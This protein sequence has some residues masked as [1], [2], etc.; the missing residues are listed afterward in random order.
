MIEHLLW[1]GNAC[2]GLKKTPSILI[3]PF[4]IP[5][6]SLPPDLI[7]ISHE[8]Y[9]NCS[10]ADVKKLRGPQ[11]QVIAS[12]T[13]ATE[14]DGEAKILRPW[15]TLNFGRMSIRAMP[16][17]TFTGE[18]PAQREDVGFLISADYTDLYYAGD[19]DFVPELRNLRCDIA[20]LP[21]GEG[22]SM[23]PESVLAFVESAKPRY[24]IPSQLKPTLS[25]TER[26]N[27][28]ALERELKR[29]TTFLKLPLT[30]STGNTGALFARN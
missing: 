26:L 16:A 27:L 25:P 2:F 22:A 1:Y 15:Q 13:A 21:M 5:H 9:Q 24:V 3:D 11:T 18:H 12:R 23:K 17:Y 20:I 14:L 4:S 19:T 29:M 10:P 30:T 8:H 6:Q 28:E 7:L